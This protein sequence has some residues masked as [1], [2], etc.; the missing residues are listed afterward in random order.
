MTCSSVSSILAPKRESGWL[1]LVTREVDASMSGAE[2][3][4][5]LANCLLRLLSS[6]GDGGGG[7]G[8]GGGTA[9]VLVLVVVVV[10]DG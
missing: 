2:L 7:D 6:A 8:G 3:G 9:V 10:C 5:L 1:M 4:R